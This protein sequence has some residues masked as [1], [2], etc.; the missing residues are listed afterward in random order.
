M[1]DDGISTTFAD[2]LNSSL[3]TPLD[4]IELPPEAYLPLLDEPRTP[5]G[6]FSLKPGLYAATVRSY[7]LHTGTHSPTEGD[8]YRP[9][10][11]RGSK[12]GVIKTIL[13]GSEKHPEIKQSSVQMLLWAILSRTK[14]QDYP[15]EV[16]AAAQTLLTSDQMVSL[17]V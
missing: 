5:D 9:A 1:P 12:S 17:M 8:G 14:A 11:L 13:Y 3:R 4:G 2:A 15:P 7:C 16:M 10:P 6:A